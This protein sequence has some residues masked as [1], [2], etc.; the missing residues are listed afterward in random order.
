M[1]RQVFE[2]EG[3]AYVRPV[4]RGVHFTEGDETYIEEA[5]E[6]MA[7]KAAGTLAPFGWSGY[8]RLKVRIEVEPDEDQS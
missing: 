7:A 8:I 3:R 6:E 1:S 5:I 2:R 4:G